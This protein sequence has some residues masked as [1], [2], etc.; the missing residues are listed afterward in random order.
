MQEVLNHNEGVNMNWSLNSSER[1]LQ[2]MTGG[3]Y[4]SH[5]HYHF[6][7]FRIQCEF[8]ASQEHF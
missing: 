8:I 3:D 5:L 1:W 2:V 4:L 7:K 6:Q